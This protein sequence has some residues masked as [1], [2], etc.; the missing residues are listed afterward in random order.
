MPYSWGRK[1][2][3]LK[4]LFFHNQVYS[5]IALGFGKIWQND[6]NTNPE[7]LLC[8]YTQE[9]LAKEYM[10]EWIALTEIKIN[11]VIEL[12]WSHVVLV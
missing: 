4:W 2:D 8:D 5:F 6:S 3:I 9:N 1:M 11:L 12:H 10:W 7:E